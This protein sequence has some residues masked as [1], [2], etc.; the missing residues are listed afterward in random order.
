MIFVNKND[1]NKRYAF[2]KDKDD[3]IMG[4][5]YV[6]GKEILRKFKNESEMKRKR[7]ALVTSGE[8]AIQTEEDRETGIKLPIYMYPHWDTKVRWSAQW[9]QNEEGNK[10]VIMSSFLKQGEK[11]SEGNEVPPKIRYMRNM[12]E[13]KEQYD[14]LKQNGWIEAEQPKIDVTYAPPEDPEIRER[15]LKEQQLNDKLME[16]LEAERAAKKE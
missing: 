2:M 16:M 4:I 12:H 15:R 3:N 14:M 5:S 11:D 7:S 13:V 6:D 8:W 9:M 1:P 10:Q